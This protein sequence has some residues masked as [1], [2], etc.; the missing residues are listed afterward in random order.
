M[1]LV[2]NLMAVLGLAGVATIAV[3]AP[4]CAGFND[5]DGASTFCPNV[6]WL[7]NREV[8]LGCATGLY[9]PNT[10]VSRLAMAAFMNRL[11][12]A[13]TP[14]Q[15]TVDAAPG[16]VDLDASAVICETAN[17]AISGYPRRA[18]L[19]LAFA[20]QAPANVDLAADLVM[21]IDNGVSWTQLTTVPNRGSVAANSWG[22]V[23]N[24]ANV[25]LD[26]GQ[27]ARFGVRVQRVSGA[28]DLADS[29][30][31]LRVLVLSRDGQ[32]SPY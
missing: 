26:V 14:Q 3:A 5:V 16:G 20:G 15:L 17:M 7:K 23:A 1:H 30:C 6:E 9:C 21:T 4:P 11:G 19:D 13:L 32:T 31:T 18:Y 25:D 12:T 29:R 8:T 27:T 10:S 24:L 22:N 2:R 28:V